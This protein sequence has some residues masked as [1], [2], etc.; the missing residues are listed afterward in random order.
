MGRWANGWIDGWL[1]GWLGGWMDEW[2]DEPNVS[3]TG[4]RFPHP[5]TDAWNT[6]GGKWVCDIFPENRVILDFSDKVEEILP[7]E[8]PQQGDMDANVSNLPTYTTGCAILP[9]HT[10]F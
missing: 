8:S 9:P 3:S 2:I 6:Y 7:G 5:A 4:S 10:P 1:G